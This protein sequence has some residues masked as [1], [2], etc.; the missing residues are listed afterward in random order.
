MYCFSKKEVEHREAE[1]ELL[2]ANWEEKQQILTK[3]ESELVESDKRLN[4]AQQKVHHLRQVEGAFSEMEKRESA[5]IGLVE[6]LRESTE[7]ARL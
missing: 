7:R 3:V 6:E 4:A 1:Y 5:L 2:Q